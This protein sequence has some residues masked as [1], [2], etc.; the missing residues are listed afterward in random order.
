MCVWRGRGSH[1]T[2]EVIVVFGSSVTSRAN[3]HPRNVWILVRKHKSWL[4]RKT[5]K[6]RA[7]PRTDYNETNS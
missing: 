7:L 3:V 2:C 4:E 5:S 1:K 6:V